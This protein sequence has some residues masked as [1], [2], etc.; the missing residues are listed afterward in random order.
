[1]VVMLSTSVVAWNWASWNY[2]N[3]RMVEKDPTT[4][5][6]VY[7]GASAILYGNPLCMNLF[8]F[9]LEPN[10]DYTLVYYGDETHN[11]EWNHVTCVKQTRTYVNGNLYQKCIHS[12]LVDGLV[13]DSQYDQ[14]LWVVLS[15][16]V[17]CSAKK[18]IAWQPAEYLFE[19]NLI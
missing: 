10:T 1:M 15:S 12:P 8:G 9:G 3:L 13:G 19:R 17:D 18:F 16:D 5:Q 2:I 11:D 7:G 4:W 14:K 6:Q